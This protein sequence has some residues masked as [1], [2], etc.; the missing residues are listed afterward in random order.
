[1]TG[2]PAGQDARHARATAVN[3]LGAEQ[4][5]RM[6]AR[7]VERGTSRL[8]AQFGER[9]ETRLLADAARLCLERVKV[10][11]ASNTAPPSHVALSSRAAR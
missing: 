6:A 8:F 3:T 2:K 10:V 9:T 11:E 5:R 1:M 4:A 7:L